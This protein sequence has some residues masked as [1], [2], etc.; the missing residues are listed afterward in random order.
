MRSRLDLRIPS[1]NEARPFV[2]YARKPA[3]RAK[4]ARRRGWSG[5]ALAALALAGWAV[6]TVAPLRHA[7][8]AALTP[9][10]NAAGFA[11]TPPAVEIAGVHA[12]RTQIDGQTLLYVEGQLV[13]KSQTAQKPPT[14]VITITGA[15]GQ[16]LY[17][18][19]S[20]VAAKTIEAAREAPFQTR[21]LSPPETFQSLKVALVNEG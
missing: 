13:N 9:A 18:W 1:Y 11:L 8:L 5:P 17:A 14:L 15:D 12:R 20:K 7:A 10:L 6:A 19:K 21:L 3:R 16:P 2:S 4:A